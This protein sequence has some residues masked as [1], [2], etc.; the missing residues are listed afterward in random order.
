VADKPADIV[1]KVIRDFE[2]DLKP[3][4]QFAR[5]VDAWYRAYRGVIEQ[6]SKAADWTSK[7]H[8]PYVFQVVETLTANVV[9]PRPR[10]RVKPRAVSGDPRYIQMLTDGARANELLL[11][12]QIDQDCLAE[13]QMLFAK[14]A[15]IAGLSVYKTQWLFAERDVSQQTVVDG[16]VNG[17]PVKQLGSEKV[18]RAVRDNNTAEVV[19]VRDFIP[20]EGAVSLD[21]CGR[22]THRVYYSMDELRQLEAQGAYGVKA[23]GQPVDTLKESRDFSGENS[24]REQELF[25]ANRT[26][27]KIEVLEQ[28][29][30]NADGSLQLVAVANRSVLLRN[31]PSPFWHGQ[32]PFSVCTPVPTSAASTASPSSNRFVIC[33]RRRGRS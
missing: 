13:K 32:Y 17:I 21:R 16:E 18:R 29:R 4:D 10:W 6:R 15:F 5:N 28:W 20:Q 23:G 14:Q 9:D 31:T 12:E 30:R 3:H 19:D 27:G 22:V 2:A 24:T 33:R 1:G 25:N 11:S 26:K 7:L 8:P